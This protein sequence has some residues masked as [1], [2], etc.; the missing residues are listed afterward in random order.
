MSNNE[1]EGLYVVEVITDENEILFKFWTP[2]KEKALESYKE[3]VEKYLDSGEYPY[4]KSI[5]WYR[6]EY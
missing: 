5:R 3:L 1:Y 6:E 2:E 4:A